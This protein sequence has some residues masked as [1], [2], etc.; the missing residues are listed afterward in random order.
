M[1]SRIAK[2]TTDVYKRQCFKFAGEDC[3]EALLFYYSIISASSISP[4]RGVLGRRRAN[5]NQLISSETVSY[6]HL[7]VYKRQG[8][9]HLDLVRRSLRS[10]HSG[11][12]HP[13]LD[14]YK[15]QVLSIFCIHNDC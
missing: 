9:R 11:T 1:W 15:R 4:F 12:G 2:R 14:V 3:R 7:D 10:L 13:P 6:T 5:L 8:K